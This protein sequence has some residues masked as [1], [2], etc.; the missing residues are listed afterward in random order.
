[1]ARCETIAKKIVLMKVCAVEKFNDRGGGHRPTFATASAEAAMLD[2]A[3]VFAP[4]TR[5]CGRSP[6]RDM[7]SSK[8]KHWRARRM[9]ERRPIY[10]A[11]KA[12]DRSP[13]RPA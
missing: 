10:P 12:W 9:G 2:R 8:R 3:R 5:V 11:G 6:D 4:S 1:L 13:S 7:P